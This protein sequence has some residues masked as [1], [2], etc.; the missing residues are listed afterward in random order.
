MTRPSFP[1]PEPN[2]RRPA[3]QDD[4]DDDLATMLR[5]GMTTT[6]PVMLMV[7]MMIPADD[8][9]Y[10]WDP[11]PML[12]TGKISMTPTTKIPNPLSQPPA[13]Q[14]ED[15]PK[16][17]TEFQQLLARLDLTVDSNRKIIPKFQREKTRK[18]P[19]NLLPSRN[20][21]I[22]QYQTDS[23]CKK[24]L[25]KNLLLPPDSSPAC[26][27]IH[28]QTRNCEILLTHLL[29]PSLPSFSLTQYSKLETPLF[30]SPSSPFP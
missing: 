1:C 6:M 2:L 11:T 17:A 20:N 8:D 23:L 21:Y 4:D 16:L 5:I 24:I 7:T 14:P 29:S 26:R 9:D 30:P 15:L 19:K 27:P 12:P 13:C 10:D 28:S 3:A 22:E 18:L 25:A